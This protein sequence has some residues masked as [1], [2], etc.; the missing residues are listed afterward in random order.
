MKGEKLILLWHGFCSEVLATKII[1]NYEKDIQIFGHRAARRSRQCRNDT[2]CLEIQQ[3][4][5]SNHQ[6]QITN[7]K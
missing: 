7:Y 6:L 3:S 1:Q 4:A 5:I 2:R